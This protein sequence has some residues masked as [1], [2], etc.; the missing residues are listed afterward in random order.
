MLQSLE[1]L[2]DLFM[3]H[4]ISALVSQDLLSEL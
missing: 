1:P 2:T 4:A 3:N